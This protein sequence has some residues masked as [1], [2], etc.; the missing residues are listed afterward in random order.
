MMKAISLF[1]VIFIV[2]NLNFAQENCTT[3]LIAGWATPDGRPMLWKNRDVSNW[4]QEFHYYDLEP[5][6]FISV[7]YS[8]D[9]VEAWGGVNEVGFAIENA[10]ALNFPDSSGVA[11]D[12]G[13]IILH[14]LQTCETVDDFLAYMDSTAFRGRTRPA[15]YGVFDVYGNGG[16]LEASL[17]NNWWF[18]L[19]DDSLAPNGVMVRANFAY[20]G[21]SNHVGQFR[22]DRALELLENAVISGEISDYFIIDIVARDLMSDSLDPYPLPFEGSIGYIPCGYIHVH[23]CINRDIT[24]SSYIVHGIQPGENPLTSTIWAQ[25]GEPIMTP[26]IP[27]W[28]GALSVPPEVDGPFNAPIC[29]RAREFFEYLY[30]PYPDP[31]D[32]LIDTW[33]LIDDRNKGLLIYLRNI[34]DSY[35]D[36]IQNTIES[37]RSN[38]PPAD[39]IAALQD[40]IA[41][42]AYEAMMNY[43]PPLPVSDAV[44]AC[45][46]SNIL[47]SWNPVNMSV[48]GDTITVSGYSIY[49]NDSYFYQRIS[50]DSLG[51]TTDTSYLIPSAIYSNSTFFQIRAVKFE[52]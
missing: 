25:V 6:A 9:T 50:G 15:I 36:Y 46:D 18:D 37:W 2:A 39:Q 48:F 22:H 8:G 41:F 43:N 44:I 26:M 49:A 3:A 1:L 16:M 33:I 47:I 51:F 35:Y 30:L 31:D 7:T 45:E 24:Q 28:V 11:D 40:S 21:S 32:D 27:L 12:D 10:N 42:L 34:E 29:E 19:N 5:F 38:F 23:N 4:A 13:L 20:M 52:E 14:A 17:Y